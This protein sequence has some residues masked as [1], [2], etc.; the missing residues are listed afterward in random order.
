MPEFIFF[1]TSLEYRKEPFID[2]LADTIPPNMAT[3]LIIIGA[4]RSGTNMLRDALCRLSNFAT[5]G[6]DEINYIWRYGNRQTLSDAIPA[7]AANPKIANFIRHQ[8]E[9]IECDLPRQS[10]RPNWIVEK[11]C[12]NSLRIPFVDRCIPHAK[13]IFLVRDGRD[14]IAS[15]MQRWQSKPESKYLLR[16]A[17]HIPPQ[18]ILHYGMRYLTNLSHRFLSA[19]K[20]FSTW[21]PMTEE[22]RTMAAT[23]PLHQVC[24]RQWKTCVEKAQEALSLLGPEKYWMIRYEDL[25][26]KPHDAFRDL[27]EF[28]ETDVSQSEI[29]RMSHGLTTSSIGRWN[30]QLPEDIAREVENQIAQLLVDYGYLNGPTGRSCGRFA[31]AA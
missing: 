14:A 28:L 26:Q 5:W 6:C 3:P 4:P 2:F 29:E 24:A 8:F 15:A 9:K 13:Y 25:V 10:T 30:T 17:R 18:D 16:K 21:G 1:G 22:L 11:T 23:G 31:A 19:E 7:S 12:A 27:F 20:R